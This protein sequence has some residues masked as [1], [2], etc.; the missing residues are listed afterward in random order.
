[1]NNVKRLIC[2]D[3][4][5]EINS[6]ISTQVKKQNREFVFGNILN[7]MWNF[8]SRETCLLLLKGVSLGE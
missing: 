8:T 4:R 7:L 3:L 5:E 6:Q 2:D 1:M